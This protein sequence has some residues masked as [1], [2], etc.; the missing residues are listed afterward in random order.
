MQHAPVRQLEVAHE[1]VCCAVV[2]PTRLP[3][4]GA[5][6]A[7]VWRRIADAPKRARST[8]RKAIHV[9]DIDART[10]RDLGISHREISSTGATPHEGERP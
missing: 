8:R 5:A 4:W 7:R 6:L 3:G 10:L 2:T 1:G 9:R